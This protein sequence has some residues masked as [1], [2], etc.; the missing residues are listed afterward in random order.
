MRRYIH[1]PILVKIFTKIFYSPGFWTITCIDL[2]LWPLIPKANQHIYEPKYICD[3]N[4]SNFPSV[5]QQ[6]VSYDNFYAHTISISANVKR[7]AKLSKFGATRCQ[8]LRLKC[9]KVD[10]RWGSVCHVQVHIW[11]NFGGNIYED[12]VFIRFFGL[13]PA[14]TLTFNLLT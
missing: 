10:F 7:T 14:V 8:I 5:D 13:L 1:D 9:T 2:D 3:R 6:F 12:I 11:P 4:W